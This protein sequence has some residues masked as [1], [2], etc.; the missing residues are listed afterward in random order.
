MSL[1]NALTGENNKVINDVVEIAKKLYPEIDKEELRNAI[2]LHWFYG[3]LDVIYRGEEI[4]SC[5]RWNI[6]PTGE[7]C[8]VLDWYVKPGENGFRIMKHFIA[9]NWRRYPGLKSLMYA[10][11]LKYKHR[12]EKIYSFKKILHLKEK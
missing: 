3:T 7:I 5:V 4:I 1:T 10:R 9:R 6:T 2:W 8:H 11:Q 12:E